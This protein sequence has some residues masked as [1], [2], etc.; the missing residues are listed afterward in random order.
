MII[1]KYERRRNCYDNSHEVKYFTTLRDFKEWFF[2]DIRDYE[3]DMYI[4]DPECTFHLHDEGPSCLNFRL[5]GYRHE[6]NQI[7]KDGK[8]IYSD[9]RYT[10]HI[11]YWNEETKQMCRDMLARQKKPQFNFG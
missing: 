10:N 2:D 8:I 11:K 3:K 4:P 6:V 1:V 9:G 7:E 5:N